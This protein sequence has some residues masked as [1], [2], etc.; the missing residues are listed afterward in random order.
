MF[1]RA[2]LAMTVIFAAPSPAASPRVLSDVGFTGSEAARYDDRR[3]EYLVSNLGA[4]PATN[5]GFIS[6]VSP[7]GGVVEL[8]WIEGGRNGATLIDP[9]GIFLHGDRLYVADVGAVR[10]F[11][12]ATGA[13]RGAIEIPDA[14]RLNDIAAAKDGTLY[15]SDSGSDDAPGAIYRITPQGQ[16]SAFVARDAALE[17]VNGIAVMPDGHIV[18]GG[19]G[20]NLVVRTP[21]GAIVREHT[22]PTGR[23]DGIVAT[24]DGGLL[25]ASQ[26]GHAVYKL[27]P[28]GAKPVAVAQDIPIPAA[29]GLDPK[30]AR[31][32]VPQIRASSLTIIDLAP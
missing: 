31:L 30:R 16:V 7:D 27:A 29:I 24:S 5:D 28:G 18:H 13:P 26:D 9:L 8:K 17:R 6:R 11:D 14:V 20:V 22:L 10:V 23:I 21:A 32:L 19:R 25:V 1:K 12:R 15:V 2:L 4:A 3:D